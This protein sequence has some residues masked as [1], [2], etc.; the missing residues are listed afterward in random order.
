MTTQAV[1]REKKE[2]S[3]TQ[4]ELNQVKKMAM[5]KGIGSRLFQRGLDD[6]MFAIALDAIKTGMRLVALPR[7]LRQLHAVSVTGTARFVAKDFFTR[8][9]SSMKF[10][11]FG[12]NFCKNFLPKVEEG[13]PAA[14]LAVW[15]LEQSAVDDQIRGELGKE[16]EETTLAHFY[17]LLSRQP[18]GEE[19]TLLVNGWCNIFYVRDAKG[20][21][22]AVLAC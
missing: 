2:K 21:L 11:Y 22:W 8:D 7:F 12:D 3:V 14:E 15:R 6:G 16:R 20:N 9:N 17:E 10:W 13:I 1:T 18:Y 4:G 19:G 5:D